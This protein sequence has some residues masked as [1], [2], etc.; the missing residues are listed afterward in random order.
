MQQAF[1]STR[2]IITLPFKFVFW[3]L[4]KIIGIPKAIGNTFGNAKDFFAEEPEDTPLGDTFAKVAANPEDIFVHLDA[5]RVHLLRAVLYVGVATGIMFIFTPRLIDFLARP[6]GGMGEM[7]AI[8]V[9][10]QVGVF[11]R[12]ALLAGFALALPLVAFEIFLFIAPGVSPKSRKFGLVALPAVTVAFVAG[13]AFAYYVMLPPAL[14]ILLH[15][16]DMKTQVRPSNYIGFVTTL[17]FWIGAFFEFP[18]VI[19]ILA[20]M[21]LVNAK[22]L[23]SQWRIAVVVIAVIAAIITPTVDPVN[24]SLVM[25]PM[26][27]LYFFSIALAALARRGR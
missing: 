10:E 22:M 17:L 26:I 18:F 3:A 5:L 19:Y 6:I 20:A 12:V 27:L 8:D 23:L 2:T 15:W 16:M 14:N 24:M 13:M 11:M 1:R 4:K 9:T 21:G 25:G 7:I